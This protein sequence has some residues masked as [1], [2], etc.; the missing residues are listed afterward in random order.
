MRWSC[1]LLLLLFS[2]AAHACSCVTSSTYCGAL[3]LSGTYFV[4]K[5]LRLREVERA[6]EGDSQFKLHRRIY[7][8]AVTEAL[9]GKAAA[10]QEIEIET[11]VGGGDCGYTFELGESYFVDAYATEGRLETGI[12]SRTSLAWRAELLITELRAAKNGGA[13]PSLAGFVTKLDPEFRNPEKPVAGVTVTATSAKGR[14]FSATTDAKG[15]YRFPRLARATYTLEF[16][17][18]S[19]LFTPSWAKPQP[20]AVPG[21][22]GGNAVCHADFVAFSGG[23]IT[24]NVVDRSGKPVAGILTASLWEKEDASSPGHIGED[25]NDTGAAYVLG[26]LSPQKYRLVFHRKDAYDP[27][28]YFPGTIDQGKGEA[29]TVEE[30][31]ATEIRFILPQL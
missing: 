29:V 3:K 2:L 21:G 31:K 9:A 20:L 10:G 5:A 25:A 28:F 7:T 27:A 16:T 1:V 24:A 18:P 17:G 30:G 14:Q 6:V 15:I 8:F 13:L 22:Q 4:G 26:P 11:G 23:S 19:G 12:C